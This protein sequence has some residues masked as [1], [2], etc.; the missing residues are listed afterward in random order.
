MVY[1]AEKGHCGG[2][3]ASSEMCPRSHTSTRA[4]VRTELSPHAPTHTPRTHATPTHQ[5]RVVFV[6]VVYNAP[7]LRPESRFVA[8]RED[9]GRSCAKTRTSG[10]LHRGTCDDCSERGAWGARMRSAAVWVMAKAW[11]GEKTGDGRVR[12]RGR[13]ARC[14]EEHAMTAASGVRG[15]RGCGAQLCGCWRKRGAARRPGTAA[16]SSGAVR[17]VRA[18]RWLRS[19]CCVEIEHTSLHFLK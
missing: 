1:G 17:R 10:A 5:Q 6:R 2:C 8:R 11:R 3:V 13:L 9:R 14:T 12:R 7:G 15:V 16:G 4:T 19:A 18:H